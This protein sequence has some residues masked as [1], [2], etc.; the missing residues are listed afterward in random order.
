MRSAPL[1]ALAALLVG[2]SSLP[3]DA[4]SGRSIDR[5]AGLPAGGLTYDVIEVDFA[6]SERIRQ[7]P[8]AADASLAVLANNGSA[9][10][11]NV[12]D[13]L[14]VSIYDPSG[15]LFGG[16]S[17]GGAS[18][19]SAGNQTLPALVVDRDGTIAIP[20]GG[21]VRVAGLTARE[22]AA[23]VVRGLRGKVANPQAIVTVADSPANGIIVLGEV[24]TPGRAPVQPGAENLL[25]AIAAAGGPTRNPDD[26]VVTVNRA[27][28]TYQAPLRRVLSTFD[29]N[30]RLRRGDQINLVYTPRR[31]SSFGS[32]A[33][34]TQTEM[35]AGDLTLTG[36]L[37]QVGGVNPISGNARSVLVFRYERPE[38][39]A[40]AGAQAPATSKGVPVI[41]RVNMAEP[42]G[43]FVANNLLIQP[44]DVV[45]VPLATAA[46]MRKFFDF[47]RSITGIAYDVRVAGTVAGN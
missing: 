30:V 39:A 11:I 33:R 23:A 14:E 47:V 44:D 12:G 17:S 42:A 15:N 25:D 27:G 46:E 5:N 45:F 36:A 21:T 26:I 3:A 29:E 37:T 41:Y 38:V 22:A 13:E 24:K 35:P 4:P 31:F 7:A 10:I 19:P 40:L 9:D 18:G 32:T 2:C 8:P 6:L 28:A 34:V 20:F 16:R 1:V 43:V